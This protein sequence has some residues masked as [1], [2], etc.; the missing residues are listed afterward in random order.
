M[1]PQSYEPYDALEKN[2]YIGEHWTEELV[3]GVKRLV[4]T[5]RGFLYCNTGH[6]L[7]DWVGHTEEEFWENVYRLATEKGFRLTKKTKYR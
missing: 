5:G 3:R 4:N 6:T 7:Y 1:Y 2:K